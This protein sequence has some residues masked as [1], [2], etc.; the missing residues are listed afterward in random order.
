M[1]LYYITHYIS[2]A[3]IQHP[4]LW[5]ILFIFMLLEKGAL[6]GNKK[7]TRVRCSSSAPNLQMI[8]FIILKLGPTELLDQYQY[9]SHFYFM[10]CIWSK[11]VWKGRRVGLRRKK[12]RQMLEMGHYVT[13]LCHSICRTCDVYIVTCQRGWVSNKP[14]WLQARHGPGI[15]QSVNLMRNYQKLKNTD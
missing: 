10:K 4:K 12:C 9:Q 11:K 13:N 1:S 8:I 6:N 2:S 15:L 5:L 3:V 14:P 7:I